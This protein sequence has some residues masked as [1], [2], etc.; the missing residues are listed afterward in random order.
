[1]KNLIFVGPPGAGKGTQANYLKKHNYH[2]VST[3][4]L[5]RAEVKS[6][7]ELGEEINSIISKGELVSD[8]IVGRLLKSNL[9]LNK[10]AYIFDGYPRNK[11][12]AGILKEILGNKPFKVIVFDADLGKLWSVSATEDLLQ[13]LERFTTCYPSH[14][15]KMVFV[16]S[17]VN[18]LSIVRMT[19]LKL[20]KIGLKSTG[21]QRLRL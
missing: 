5:L 16:M 15:K 6:G 4:D 1:M 11:K 12:Q 9:D 19:K 18:L 2:H 17:P 20:L 14:L 7:S 3:G 10:H 8:D 13:T 21:K